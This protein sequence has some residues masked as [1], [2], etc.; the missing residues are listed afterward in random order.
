MVAIIIIIIIH[1]YNLCL[2]C[3]LTETVYAI[4]ALISLC[5]WNLA[6]A[7]GLPLSGKCMS[8]RENIIGKSE[9]G[10]IRFHIYFQ[11]YCLV[12]TRIRYL[13]KFGAKNTTHW[14]VN[15]NTSNN[16]FYL[17]SF[18]PFHLLESL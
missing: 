16:L 10:F 13:G 17:V 14:K 4:V 12:R 5:N 2:E 11:N 3:L 6:P 18:V 1:K 15:R 8:P 7:C 9:K